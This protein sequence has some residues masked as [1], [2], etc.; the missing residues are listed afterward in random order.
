[1][2]KKYIDKDNKRQMDI[3]RNK[4]KEK[5]KDRENQRRIE[6]RDEQRKHRVT[7]F[8]YEIDKQNKRQL[9]RQNKT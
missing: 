8:E 2:E 9:D 1:M 5:E 7:Y 6:K 3:I 4:S